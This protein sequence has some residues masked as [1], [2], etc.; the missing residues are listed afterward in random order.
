MLAQ[1]IFAVVVAVRS[2]H[3]HVDVIPIRLLISRERLTPLVVELNDDDGA[4]DTIVEHTVF[5]H[6]AHPGKVGL[7]EM[8]LHLF[9]LYFSVTWP[10]AAE[11]NLNQAE[12]EVTLRTRERVV[13]DP[14]VTEFKII[15]E[16]CGKWLT[17]QIQ[18]KDSLIALI[19]R[20]RPDHRQSLLLFSFE[21]PCAGVFPALGIDRLRT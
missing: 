6:A 7:P 13:V 16:G 11:M 2:A 19:C 10:D 14:L 3:D 17:R 15:A 21:D 12:Q 8:P 5:F 18:G 9:L 4:M 20:K 1:E